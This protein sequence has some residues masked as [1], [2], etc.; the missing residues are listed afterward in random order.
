MDNLD[1]TLQEFSQYTN[2]DSKLENASKYEITD[3]PDQ[4]PGGKIDG[5]TLPGIIY[6]QVKKQKFKILIFYGIIVF[7]IYVVLK[8]LTY[9]IVY[10][11]DLNSFV[12]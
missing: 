12:S 11:R 5:K 2:Y 7:L 6:D 8:E 10:E 3:A 4:M 1:S 9:D